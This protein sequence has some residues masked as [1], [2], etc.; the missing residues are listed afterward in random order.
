MEYQEKDK[1]DDILIDIVSRATTLT[2]KIQ[3]KKHLVS[4]GEAETWVS[5]KKNG[6][7]PVPWKTQR[8][9]GRGL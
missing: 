9:S 5:G 1:L 4:Y 3:Y 8:Y 6:E 7:R 2:E